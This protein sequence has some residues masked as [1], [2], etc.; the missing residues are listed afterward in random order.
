MPLT[1]RQT[2]ALLRAAGMS[3]AAAKRIAPQ[4]LA[5]LA[6]LS[7]EGTRTMPFPAPAPAPA[8]PSTTNLTRALQ[9]FAPDH[10][11]VA[12]PGTERSARPVTV[13]ELLRAR[14]AIAE[15][16]E[17]DA[18]TFDADLELARSA[19]AEIDQLIATRRAAEA[20]AARTAQP[21]AG[22]EA[23]AWYRNRAAG[24]GAGEA[25]S[26]PMMI[27][28]AATGQLVRT[29]AASERLERSYAPPPIGLGTWMRAAV[30]GRWDQ[31][32]DQV[33]AASIGIGTSGGFLVPPMMSSEIVDLARAQTR[34]MQAGSRTMPMPAGTMTIAVVD[35]DPEPAWRAENSAFAVS[36]GQ[37]GQ[38][39]MSARM[40]GA[41]VPLSIELV[42][43]ASNVDQLV[44]SQLSAAIALAIDA[45]CIA[46]DGTQNQP[47][48]ILPKIPAG[49]VIPVGAALSAGN[50][51]P[52]YGQAI[53]KCLAANA[54]LGRLAVL[55]NSNVDVALDAL[56]D[57]L[58][59]PLRP[60]P[61]FASIRDRGGLYVAN[62]IATTGTPASS[63]AVVGD[64]SSLL[65]GMTQEMMIEVSREGGYVESGSTKSAFAQGQ[66]LIRAYT[67][68][69]CAVLRPSFFAK[70]DDIRFA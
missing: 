39:V 38:I 58:G 17:L 27:R 70:V 30:T 34:V 25:A 62:G 7:P 4:R 46:A 61:N 21:V 40:I 36:Q 1:L 41:I 48:G 49:N 2:E 35:R 9:R 42:T 14:A 28:D 43:M 59:Q 20:D 15:G 57:T 5:E 47:C 55:H 60:T 51:Y 6:T 68:M 29:Y 23:D 31:V 67:M 54:E 16:P 26:D 69:D 52:A 24:Q 53:G 32:P 18:E 66:V 19:L 37:Y 44:T 12:D 3:A 22:Q 50:A 65:V 56:V 64:F 8:Q 11:R 10:A 13:A 63:Y 45:A 33:R